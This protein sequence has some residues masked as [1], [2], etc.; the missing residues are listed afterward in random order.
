MSN[1]QVFY[2]ILKNK[3]LE[4]LDTILRQEE[5]FWALKSQVNWLIQGNHNTAF[6]HVSTLVRRKRNQILAIKDA[7]GEWLYEE[8]AMK[9]FIRDGF[10]NVYTTSLLS[11]SRSYLPISQWQARLSKEEM[12]SI[13]GGVMEE[14]IKATLWLLKA[15]KALGLVGLH[16]G[17][18]Q[19]FWLIIGSSVIEKV[20]RVF[21]ERKVPSY[22]NKTHIAL[23]PKIQGPKTLG[24]YRPISL[25]NIVYKVITKVIVARL[26]LYLDRLISLH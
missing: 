11:A 13:S 3:L 26:R 16:A 20:K 25:C 19:R 6:Y 15:Y 7:M 24:N 23:I 21:A 12:R 5:E 10:N 9:E 18:V 22:L 4:K 1:P 17:F 2:S 8:N 14:E